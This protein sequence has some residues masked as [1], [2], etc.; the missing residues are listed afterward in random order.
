[1]VNGVSG[2]TGLNVQQHVV[3]EREEE[4]VCV[5]ILH[6]IMEGKIAME[7]RLILQTATTP[8]VQ[9]MFAA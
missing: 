5:T 9:V 8:T 4:S 7:T 1:M 6:L 3:T 2:E